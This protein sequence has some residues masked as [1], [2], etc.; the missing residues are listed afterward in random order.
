MESRRDSTLAVEFLDGGSWRQSFLYVN[1]RVT[2]I[3][4]QETTPESYDCVIGLLAPSQRYNMIEEE[5]A[6]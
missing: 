4:Y 5:E 2:L 1:T 6:C 3:G